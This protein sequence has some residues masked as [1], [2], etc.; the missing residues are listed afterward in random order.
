MTQPPRS[1]NRTGADMQSTQGGVWDRLAND[2][3]SLAYQNHRQRPI[4]SFA[5]PDEHSHPASPF[6]WPIAKT[7][8]YDVGT[9]EFAALVR[10][11]GAEATR[12]HVKGSR[13]HGTASLAARYGLDVSIMRDVLEH[14][15]LQS[16]T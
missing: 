12:D 4:E 13:T 6:C 1:S 5:I 14:A 9:R 10:R 15:S 7:Q 8:R 2:L 3:T 16:E 11:I